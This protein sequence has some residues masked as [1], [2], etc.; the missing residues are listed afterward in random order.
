MET[1]GET[2]PISKENIAAMLALIGK[3]QQST[4]SPTA[5][6]MLGNLKDNLKILF[7]KI[8]NR[9]LDFAMVRIGKGV[10]L[11][12]VFYEYCRVGKDLGVSKTTALA[13]TMNVLQQTHGSRHLHVISQEENPMAYEFLIEVRY[14]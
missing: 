8:C 4:T 2:F 9:E 12:A 5:I 10:Q 3:E 13:N 6:V 1:F 14:F 11:D 7:D